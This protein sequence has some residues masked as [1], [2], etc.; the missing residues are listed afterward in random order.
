MSKINELRAQRAKTWEQTKAFL[1]SHRNEKGILSAEDTQTYER[2]EQEV[3]DL[4]HEIDRQERLEAMERELAA[5]VNTPI[6]GKPENTKVDEKTGRASDA[7]RNAFWN[8]VRSAHST[9]EIRNALQ[10]GTDSEGGYLV[11]DEFERTL[12]QALDE[13]NVIRSHAHVFTT[14]SGSHKIPVVKTKGTASWIDEGGAYGESDDV[15]GQEQI[16]AHKIGTIIKVSE[17]LLND[18]VFNLEAYFSG[19]FVR[20]FGN[21]EEEAFLVG[22]GSK[23]P[24]GLLN[25][26]GGADVGITAASATAITADEVIDLF[27]SLNSPYRNSAIWVM[28]DS[29]VRAIRKLKDS[30]GQYLWQ[31]AI[32]EGSFDTL[33]GKRI[34]TS[35]FMPTIASGNKSI[36]FGDLSYYWIGDRQ[37]ITFKRLNERYADLGQVGFLAYKRLDAKLILPEAVKVL[38]QKKSA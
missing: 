34:Y 21:T 37:G 11:P 24:T 15:F 19:E 1:D 29:T 5:P 16:D 13:E 4:G 20:R 2:M 35:P 32:R 3:V 17:E 6:T 25:A 9:Q 33:L 22:D 27:Y 7:Y 30:N 36:L 26:T 14:S 18:S 28:H 12:V 31:P 8:V 10:E 23:K 38:A